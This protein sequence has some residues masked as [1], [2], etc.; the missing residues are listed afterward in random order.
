MNI[1]WPLVFFTLLVGLGCG[2]FV[3]SVI[4]TEWW[5]RAE[6]VRVKS[7]ILALIALALGG[8]SSVLHLG[9]PERIFGALG[10][11]TSGIF[12]ESTMIALVGLDIIIYLIA[13][14][15]G[16][17]AAA[18]KI[19]TTVGAVLAVIL[20][21][22]VGYSYV[23]ASRPAWDT[24]I[25]PFFYL[26]SAGVMGCFSLNAL[27]AGTERFS[28]AAKARGERNAMTAAAAEAASPGA[29]GADLLTGEAGEVSAEAARLHG[30][31]AGA[32]LTETLNRSALII[33]TVQAVLLIAYLVHLG[34]VPYP[35]VTRSAGRALTGN[36]A[37]LFWLGVVLPG[38]L[39][40]AGLS[41]QNILKRSKSSKANG[42]I[43]SF[44]LLNLGLLCILI[45]G[46]SF[47]ILMFSLGSSIIKFF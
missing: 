4:V 6:E 32:A 20:S 2:T 40:P 19:I 47:R 24:L 1:E 46:A 8:F 13:L 15:R 31:D 43:S 44:S 38:F 33:L 45:G 34:L 5:G 14:R 7:A 12:I 11:P 23:V 37:P 17:D 35:D 10:H 26:V 39:I 28:A 30:P 42:G 18:R 16:A 21:F 27:I 25:L 3:C 41:L 36:L 9:H 29:E 22:A